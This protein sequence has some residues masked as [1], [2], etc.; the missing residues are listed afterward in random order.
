MKKLLVLLS[1]VFCVF[2]L[3]FIPNRAF[4]SYEG[5]VCNLNFSSGPTDPGQQFCLVGAENDGT[6]EFRNFVCF[7]PPNRP[8]LLTTYELVWTEDSPYY[9][10]Y[11]NGGSRWMIDVGKGNDEV[12]V[13]NTVD[14][15]PNI[16]MGPGLCSCS[17]PD[18]DLAEVGAGVA[19]GFVQTDFEGHLGARDLTLIGGQGNDTVWAGVSGFMIF[20]GGGV[21]WTGGS[22]HWGDHLENGNDTLMASTGWER[23]YGQNSNDTMF[24]YYDAGFASYSDVY[25]GSG[26]DRFYDSAPSN[27][28][29][30]DAAGHIA[31]DRAHP[32]SECVNEEFDEVSTVVVACPAWLPEPG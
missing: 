13:N 25:L 15:P 4:A 27:G 19:D 28:G 17:C 31:G 20:Y 32:R 23:F 5:E 18:A 2:S 7:A 6:N 16:V 12:V 24:N 11:V 10:T 21:P 14:V 9:C 1:L 29:T 3:S 8:D 30:C 22:P 26:D